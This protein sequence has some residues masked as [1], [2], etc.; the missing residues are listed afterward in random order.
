LNKKYKIG[1]E[2]ELKIEKIVPRGL[3]LAFAEGLTVFV[4][5]AAAGDSIRAEIVEIK[6]RSA[7]A[8]IVS[9]VEPSSERIKPPC[10]YFGTCGGCDFMHLNYAAQ[11]SAK[12]AMIRDCIER[13]GKI[14]Y[15]KE[16]AVIESPSQFGYRLRAQWHADPATGE[17]GYYQRNSRKLVDV[18]E[19]LVLVPELQGELDRCREKLSPELAAGMMQIDAAAGDNGEVST[20]SADLLE[21]ADE[22]GFTSAGERLA[23]SA[24]SFFQGNRFLVDKLVEV[25][26][27]EA[28]GETA[29]DLYC[30]V[31]LFTLPLARRFKTVIGVEDNEKA[32]EFA[33]ANAERA[34]LENVDLYEASVRDYMASDEV[35][36]PDFVL[37]DPP[38]AGTEKE[39]IMNLIALEPK[40]VSYVACEPSI[41]ARDLRRFVDNGYEIE[42]ITALDLFPQTHHV[43]TVAQLVRTKVD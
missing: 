23:F 18:K 10:P 15:Q 6:G 17:I 14:D 36:K 7:F 33:N 31:G 26:I 5:L 4:P 28:S 42:S 30:G 32:V 41:L 20:Y 3:G 19:C 22:I 37:L 21:W 40:S 12:V 43:E 38:R 29:L 39:T 8:E 13:I 27:G 16:I 35:P 25:A 11:L 1:D 24:R 9:V 2:L 34:G